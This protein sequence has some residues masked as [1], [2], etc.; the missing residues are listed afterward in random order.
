MISRR[1]EKVCAYATLICLAR[2][3]HALFDVVLPPDKIATKAQKITIKLP[4]EI[5]TVFSD[6]LPT[7]D[8]EDEDDI[9][10]HEASIERL[11]VCRVVHSS[12]LAL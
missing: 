3:Q 4:W 8:D 10:A 7:N 2:E 11:K 9:E 6:V 5:K 1:T 12:L